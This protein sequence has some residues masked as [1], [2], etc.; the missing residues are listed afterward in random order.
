VLGAQLLIE[1]GDDLV[2][3]VRKVAEERGSTYVLLGTPSPR[4]G[5]KRFRPA[6]TT[7][8]IEALPGVDLRVVADRSLIGD[9][10]EAS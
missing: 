6:L 1:E 10:G 5:L 4:A 3:A 7:R 9:E 2:Q 8:L